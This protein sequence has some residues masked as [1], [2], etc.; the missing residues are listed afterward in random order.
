MLTNKLFSRYFL[1]KI[2]SK[3]FKE[4]NAISQSNDILILESW[5]PNP[6]P[7]PPDR[8][9]RCEISKTFKTNR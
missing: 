3:K 1:I 5:W 2:C 4:V 8:V 9:K 6:E 7:D